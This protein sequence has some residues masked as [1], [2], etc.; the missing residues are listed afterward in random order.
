MPDND[1]T[2]RVPHSLGAA[3]AKRRI[4]GGVASARAQFGQVLKIADAE[5]EPTV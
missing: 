2:V 3:E 5:W 4:V 1:I